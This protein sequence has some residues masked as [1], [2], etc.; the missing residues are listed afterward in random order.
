MLGCVGP[1]VCAEM[2]LAMEPGRGV[3][4]QCLDI[5]F[6]TVLPLLVWSGGLVLNVIVRVVGLR[7]FGY[8]GRKIVGSENTVRVAVVEEVAD[9]SIEV[10]EEDCFCGCFD[11]VS[12]HCF[13]GDV[14]EYEE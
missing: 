5:A 9:D 1:A 2:V 10:I 4:N 11:R 14:P 7:C 3:V 8:E 12:E 13:A 6:S